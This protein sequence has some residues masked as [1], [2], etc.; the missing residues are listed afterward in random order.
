MVDRQLPCRYVSS[1]AVRGVAGEAKLDAKRWVG[2]AA[3]IFFSTV[4]KMQAQK[5]KTKYKIREEI[6]L[7]CLNESILEITV[8][9]HLSPPLSYQSHFFRDESV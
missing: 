6:F 2:G 5:M 1:C 9:A 7:L 8:S 4:F 3:A